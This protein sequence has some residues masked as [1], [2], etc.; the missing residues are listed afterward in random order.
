MSA[1]FLSPLLT[2]LSSIRPTVRDNL[3][4]SLTRTYTDERVDTPE[5]RHE[6]DRR[7]Q[8]RRMSDLLGDIA[9]K[10]AAITRETERRRA[11]GFGPQATAEDEPSPT[12]TGDTPEEGSTT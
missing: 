1:F 3:G 6:P 2:K 11:T 8:V 10:H 9:G 5:R 7:K 4:Q 12:P